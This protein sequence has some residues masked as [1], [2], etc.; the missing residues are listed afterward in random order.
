[1]KKLILFLILTFQAAH[2]APAEQDEMTIIGRVQG[3]GSALM[4]IRSLEGDALPGM[5]ER[6]QVADSLAE[7]KPGDEVLIKGYV[8]YERFTLEGQTQLRPFFI[9]QSLRP[10]SLSRLGN[11]EGMKVPDVTYNPSPE[12]AYSPLAIPITTQVASAITM[13]TSILMLQSLSYTEADPR[14]RQQINS[15][16]ILFAGAMATGIFIYEQ[17]VGTHNKGS[18][19]D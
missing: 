6:Q 18:N 9:V 17:I 15:G 19:N 3:Q 10:I 13:T 7:L 5:L 14:V 8:S 2:A 4:V 11:T 16:L 12:R 1:M